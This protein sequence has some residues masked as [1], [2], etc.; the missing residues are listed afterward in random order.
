VASQYKTLKKSHATFSIVGIGQNFF[1]HMAAVAE[2]NEVIMRMLNQ[3]KR[4]GKNEA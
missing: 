2:M 3:H 1:L 4:Q